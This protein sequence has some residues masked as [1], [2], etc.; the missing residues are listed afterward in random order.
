MK[1]FQ[2]VT[3]V[4]VMAFS[5]SGCMT[6]PYKAGVKALENGEYKEAEEQFSKAVKK[7]KNTADA[8]RGLEIACWESED[9][10]GA[11]D[12]LK[13]ALEAGTKKNGTIYNILGCSELKL[14]NAKEAAEYFEEGLKDK[15]ISNELKQEMRFN[16][17]SAYE[18]MG[19]LETAKTLIANYV[20]DYPDD[21]QAA[22]EAQFLET[23]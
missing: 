9:Y 14:G 18:Q 3:L 2:M 8:Y 21:E 12:A 11:S 23:R 17:I 20:N 5:L 15:D 1:R 22:K 13:K 16:M 10:E 7:D 4:I 19:D 6:N